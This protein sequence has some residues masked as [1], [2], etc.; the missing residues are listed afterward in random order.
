MR[1]SGGPYCNH[2]QPART[3]YQAVLIVST[4]A[5]YCRVTA[6]SRAQII[7]RR[8]SGQWAPDARV[9]RGG[10]LDLAVLKR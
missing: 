9:L 2:P 8:G 1:G 3:R 6:G 7:L 5:V 10:F 4:R